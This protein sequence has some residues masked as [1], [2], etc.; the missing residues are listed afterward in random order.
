M[1]IDLMSNDESLHAGDPLDSGMFGQQW[2]HLF[3]R[4]VS[5]KTWWFGKYLR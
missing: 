4:K 3:K 5:T 1:P 2:S